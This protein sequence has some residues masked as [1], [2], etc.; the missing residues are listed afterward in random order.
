[1]PEGRG[2]GLLS[3]SLQRS[4]DKMLSS[5]LFVFFIF[6]AVFRTEDR[7]STMLHEDRPAVNPV[8]PPPHTLWD[9]HASVQMHFSVGLRRHCVML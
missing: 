8:A 3:N 2:Q 1:M 9:M 5:R 4:M 6:I 7:F